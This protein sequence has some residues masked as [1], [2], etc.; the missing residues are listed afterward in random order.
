MAL[1]E[2]NY[3]SLTRDEVSLVGQLNVNFMLMDILEAFGDFGNYS[4]QRELFISTLGKD[5]LDKS[6]FGTLVKIWDARAALA[7]GDIEAAYEMISIGLLQNRFSTMPHIRSQ[8]L[9]YQ[10]LIVSLAGKSTPQPLELAE[11]SRILREKSGG[12]YFAARNQIILALVYI[13]SDM[14]E[15]GFRLFDE[16]IESAVNTDLPMV[17]CS[18]FM[19]RAYANMFVDRAD[20]L[21][22]DLASGLKIM[23]KH[24]YHYFFCWYPPL[25]K[26]LLQT[27]VH[28]NIETTYAKKLAREQLDL[29]IQNSGE[30]VPLLKIRIL[31]SFNLELNGRI[32]ATGSS[33]TPMQREL[34]AVLLAS[35]NLQLE[36]EKI[37]FELWPDTTTEKAH[38]GFDTLMSRL[39]TT[40]KKLFSPYSLKHYFVFSKGI[41]SF[42]N[43]RLD[44]R[45]FTTLAEQGMDHI[46]KEEYWQ[47]GN[48]FFPAMQL[49][50]GCFTTD[51][52]SG[53][54]AHE[55][56]VDLH[57]KISEM[58]L[59]WGDNLSK[60]G[61]R[62]EAL[63]VLQQA[64]NFNRSHSGLVK[65][66]YEHY[67]YNNNPIQA[68]QTLR[69]YEA[70]L[71][72]EEF[73][74]DEIHEIISHMSL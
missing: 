32:V 33:F 51:I 25:V 23:R 21:K 65:L 67:L 29:C 19:L 42:E 18:G 40:M 11:Q 47:A 1:A 60:I 35:P 8:L 39:R 16:G 73:S 57:H 50:R 20:D 59:A 37:Q 45:E 22:K 10:A 2:K 5:Y 49:W 34:F 63:K 71:K 70:I 48:Y 27:A 55:Y 13:R 4:H 52:F 61:Y 15:K 12:V 68:R 17:V 38:A 53:E 44:A 62:Q 36:R 24:R 7:K 66:L 43:C 14:V 69:Q 56:C 31:G 28:Y 26:E 3:S 74:E 41:L 72:Q 64:W 54:Q 9:E 46:K 6:I 58:A 30:A